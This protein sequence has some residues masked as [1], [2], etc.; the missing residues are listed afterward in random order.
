MGIF[1]SVWAFFVLSDI[2][3]SPANLPKMCIN[4]FIPVT[5]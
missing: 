5:T 2:F 4:G 3:I 1:L